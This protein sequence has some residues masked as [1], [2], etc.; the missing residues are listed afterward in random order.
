MELRTRLE[1]LQRDWM[2]WSA[3][4][5]QQY[6]SLPAGE[7]AVWAQARTS[8][9]RLSSETVAAKLVVPPLWHERAL[10][11]VVGA[12]LL[13]A[14]GVLVGLSRVAA[15]RRRAQELERLVV[16]RT[17]DLDA[18]RAKAVEASTAK[19][20]LL[21]RMSHELR[22]PLGAMMG[23]A[24][25]I[26]E[27]D[28]ATEEVRHHAHVITDAGQKLLSL[29]RSILELSKA[30]AAVGRR[31]RVQFDLKELVREV[32]E[33]LSAPAG[34]K[35][36]TLGSQEDGWPSQPV[37]GD[38]ERLREVLI[39]LVGNALKYTPEGGN[40]HVTCR[41]DGHAVAISVR[42]SG[43]GISPDD[44]KRIF[45]PFVRLGGHKG[46]EEGAGLGLTITKQLVEA[47]GGTV[48]V[49]SAL[50]AGS[51]FTVTLPRE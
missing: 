32:L 43:P 19:S 22:T 14:L 38:P 36:I 50:G 42:D 2:P 11:R 30:E 7:Y 27:A 26:A 46:G 23:F 48:I 41:L 10:V 4:W 51:T 21:S 17:A 3:A 5:A 45:D 24:D 34:E 29:I 39:N 49:E 16:Q 15:S 33:L 28:E 44:Q 35:G 8:D 37:W 31:V 12:L 47:M 25:L 9:G 18:A 1:P 13:L 20:V 6:P 40:V